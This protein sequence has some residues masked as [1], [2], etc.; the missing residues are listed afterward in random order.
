[1]RNL[2]VEQLAQPRQL[3]GIAQL[4]GVDHLVRQ[5]AEGA[6]DRGIVGAAPR[7]RAGAARPAGIV[8]ARTRHHLAIAG[9]GRVLGILG[10][11]IGGR[12]VGRGLRPGGGALAFALVLALAFLALLLLVAFRGILGFAEIDVEILQH[13]AGGARICVLVENGAIE[14][15]EILGDPRFQPRA[16]QIDDAARRGRRPFAGQGLAGQQAHRLGHRAL[17]ALGDALEAL[18]AILLVEHRGEIAGDPDH[19]PRAQGLDPR[20]LDRLEYRARQRAAGDAFA[21]HGVV[22]IAHAQGHAVGGAAQLRGLLG[23]QVA[24]RVRQP[25]PGAAQTGRLGAKGD[26]QIVALGDRP[27]RR[28]GRPLE[29]FGRGE[30]LRHQLCRPAENARTRR[31]VITGLDPV[32][33]AFSG[34]AGS[35]GWPEQVRP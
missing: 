19:P 16:P 11:A 24:R 22:V 14:F 8:V 23:R 28:R 32:I 12:A 18:P 20:L 2:L 33:H 4:V 25:H 21:V 9:F 3:V 15:A 34:R 31:I 27:Q 26:G 10:L 17:G 6:I 30:F 1:M 5:G 35:R 13:A 7:H 29:D